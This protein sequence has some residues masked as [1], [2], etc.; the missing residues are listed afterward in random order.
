MSFELDRYCYYNFYCSCFNPEILEFSDKGILTNKDLLEVKKLLIFWIQKV[1]IECDVIVYLC[2]CSDY[3]RTTKKIF[4]KKMDSSTQFVND[5]L[6][7][8]FLLE[9]VRTATE[10][11]RFSNSIKLIK[12][13]SKLRF[14]YTNLLLLKQIQFPELKGEFTIET[15]KAKRARYSRI[16]NE[17]PSL[18]DFE[19]SKNSFDV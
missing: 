2:L 8:L 12:L 3:E 5:A 7:T 19:G 10:E 6:E 17:G 13:K 16:I 11:F 9:K 15:D 4:D 1:R 18:A 14:C